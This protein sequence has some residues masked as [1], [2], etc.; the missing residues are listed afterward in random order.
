MANLT[1][2]R[3]DE[4]AQIILIAAFAIAV[5]FVAL[6]LVVNSAIFTENLA[7]RGESTG[8]DDSL[9][10]RHE[11]G[12]SVGEAIAHANT[13]NTSG[14]RE[15]AVNVTESV[16][17][18]DRSITRQQSANGKIV[19]IDGPTSFD[20][21]T[22]IRDN[23]SGGSSFLNATDP[24]GNTRPNWTVAD[25]VDDTRAYQ[26]TIHE[27]ASGGNNYGG[28]RADE[29]YVNLTDGSD[30]W[31]MNVTNRSDNK[32][33][34][35]ITGPSW[36][37]T[38]TVD[39]SVDEFTIDLTRGVVG[40]E[41]CPYMNFSSG[42]S[43][44]YDITYNNSD[45]VTGNYS[46][47]ISNDDYSNANL[48]TVS[49]VDDDPFTSHAIYAATVTYRYDGSALTYNTSVRAAPGEPR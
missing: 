34:V 10:V 28:S 36:S 3:R 49:G 24:T 44:P 2:E 8:S 14:E 43:T 21:G 45:E 15:Q 7:S 27:V 22:R 5:T 31:H 38:C 20:N 30:T 11:V 16:V 47:V 37:G 4:R 32:Y 39:D 42:I 19:T 26:M 33:Y 13:Y 9:V 17:T 6:A 40:G 35:G 18:I 29:F 1:G 12:Q 23:A 46:L 41:P 48:S 25:G